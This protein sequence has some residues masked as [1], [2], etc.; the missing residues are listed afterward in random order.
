[1]DYY[2]MLIPHEQQVETFLE[3]LI[4]DL[5]NSLWTTVC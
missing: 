3:S 2:A 4:K 5:L 1:M